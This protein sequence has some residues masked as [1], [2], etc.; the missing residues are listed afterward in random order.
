M[1]LYY[2]FRFILFVL[3]KLF[4]HF[5]AEGKN[6]VP[7][8]GGF[9]L[10]SNH[11]SFLDPMILGVASPRGLNFAARD[12]LFRGYFF[13]RLIRLCGAFP[14][15]RWSADLS[16]IKESV[17]RLKMGVGLVVF[18]E[19]TRSDDGRVSREITNGFVLLAKKAQVPIVP[20]VILGS[21]KAWGKNN[22]AIK[23]GRLKVIF[24]EP[25]YLTREDTEYVDIAARLFSRI[26][27]RHSRELN[28]DEK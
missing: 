9:L 25:F 27:S 7:K 13:G 21:E 4:F 17:R 2:F 18:P 6:F 11:A 10:I 22:K 24:L 16:A 20:A 15:K 28:Y 12:S 14:V 8:S 23:P 26:Q 19:G 5:K 3:F 1:F